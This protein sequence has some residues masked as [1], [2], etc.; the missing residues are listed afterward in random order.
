MNA[1]LRYEIKAQAFYNLTGVIAP[2]KDIPAGDPGK[3][4]PAERMEAWDRFITEEG[5]TVNA[6]L[7][8]VDELVRCFSSDI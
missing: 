3:L 1:S 8:A 7:D 6:V 5:A 2:G 4:T